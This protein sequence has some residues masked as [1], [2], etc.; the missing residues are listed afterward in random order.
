MRRPL[1]IGLLLLGAASCDNTTGGALIH[2]PMSVG[3]TGTRTFTTPAPLDW[4]VTLSRAR[5]ALGPYYF[6]VSKEPSTTTVRTGV[7][8]IQATVQSI[9]DPLDVTLQPLS[10]GADGESGT[11]FTAEIGLLPPDGTES[12]PDLALLDGAQAYVEG[13]AV[14]GST[15]V[16]FAGFV[17]IDAT[18]AT[19]QTPLEA[20]QRVNGASVDLTFTSSEQQLTMRVD[21]TH[22]F[23]RTDFSLLL[24]GTPVDGV[25]TWTNTDTF[26]AQL[27][28]GVQLTVG[29]Y[30]FQFSPAP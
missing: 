2:L 19:P 5:I 28:S 4:T 13:T 20:L 18:L 10:G 30:D 24:A 9:V 8:I 7:V 11:A 12:S 15:T 3:G 1:A 17:R 21:P 25:Y 29:V 27:L 6:N 14:K 16:P 23:D 22:W 26:H